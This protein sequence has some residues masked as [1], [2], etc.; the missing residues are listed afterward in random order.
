LGNGKAIEWVEHPDFC[1]SKAKEQLSGNT[2]PRRGNNMKK[3]RNKKQTDTNNATRA[4]G[5][6]KDTQTNAP[7][8]EDRIRQRA[9]EV[10]Q[11]RGGAPG[12]ELDDWLQAERELKEEMA[13]AHPSDGPAGLK[14][15][16]LGTQGL[17]V[18][19]WVWGAWACPT[20]TLP[21]TK[22]KPLPPSTAP[23]SL[24]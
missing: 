6:E 22:A 13:R 20:S 18:S 12:C 2:T 17:R 21:A 24:A 23:L 3:Q 7:I 16:L 1:V 9:Y 4:D 11:T 5:L 14:T 19:T 15:R 10:S 8:P